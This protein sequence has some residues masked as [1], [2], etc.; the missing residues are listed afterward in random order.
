[1]ADDIHGRGLQ[2]YSLCGLAFDA[3]DTGD[4]DD[5]IM[6]AESGETVTC[7]QCRRA[8]DQFRASFKG[9]RAV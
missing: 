2:E 5:P 9:Y 6:F 8:L 7:E 1:M 4:H 3:F